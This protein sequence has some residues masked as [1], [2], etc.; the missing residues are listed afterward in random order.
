MTLHPQNSLTVTNSYILERLT[1]RTVRSGIVNS[2]IVRSKLNYQYNKEL[3]VRAIFQ[4]NSQLNG[5]PFTSLDYEKNFN[6]DLLITYLIH[7][8][9]ALYL[10]YN[11]NL[12]NFD[13]DA[14]TS[15][16]GLFRTK[17]FIND[18]RAI[19]A[20]ISYLFRF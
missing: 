5:P 2:H 6:A 10:G 3:S 1:A 12:E 20:K 19:Y 8:G 4:Y 14:I 17:G 18:G 9:T 13:P 15:H 11:S 16:A 7:P